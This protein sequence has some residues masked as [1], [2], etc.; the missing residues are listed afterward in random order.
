MRTLGGKAPFVR[1]Y[2]AGLKPG[3]PK[4]TSNVVPF[5]KVQDERISIQANFQDKKISSE[6]N[7]YL[8]FEAER[9]RRS[10]L[11]PG[12]HAEVITGL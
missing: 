5:N 4:S 10:G 12:R 9:F 11:Q 3:P 2:S 7:F 1:A 8:R 6:E